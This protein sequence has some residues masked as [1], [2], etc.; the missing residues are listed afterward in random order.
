MKTFNRII[1]SALALLTAAACYDDGTDFIDN[2][3]RITLT[4]GVERFN[5]DGTI[6]YGNETFVAAVGVNEG[7]AL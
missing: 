2:A 1:A 6:E 7:K 5:A 4:P 3:T